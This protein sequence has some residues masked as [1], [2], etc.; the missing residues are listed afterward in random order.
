MSL[1]ECSYLGVGHVGSDNPKH[2][3]LKLDDPAAVISTAG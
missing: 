2:A 1:A 3:R